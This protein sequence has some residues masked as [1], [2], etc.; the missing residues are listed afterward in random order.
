[1][2]LDN[3]Y[4]WE[5]TTPDL[6]FF[7][8]PLEG[9][10]RDYSFANAGNEIRRVAAALKAMALPPNSNIAILSKNCAHWIM[11]DLAIWMAGHVSVPLYP[12][13]SADSIR[14]MLDHSESKVIFIGK[15]DD[16]ESQRS[17]IPEAVQ[18]VSFALYGPDEGLKWADL[19]KIYPGLEGSITRNPEELVTIMYTSGTTGVPKGVMFNFKQLAWTA[20]VAVKSLQ[21]NFGFPPVAQ[22]AVARRRAMYT[23]SWG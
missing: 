5:K 13:L 6:I 22:H 3:F 9:K 18:K 17:G 1:M 12:N 19:L 21:E 2:P 11:A 16:Y 4:Y 10:W 20:D 7:R 23:T 8:Q 15:L 14:Q